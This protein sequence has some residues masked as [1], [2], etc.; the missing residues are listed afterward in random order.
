MEKFLD[1]D[2]LVA[3][4]Q[5]VCIWRIYKYQPHFNKMEIDFV[6]VFF[7]L[8]ITTI[9]RSPP[10]IFGGTSCLWATFS[11]IASFE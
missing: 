5:D 9:Q 1:N 8:G 11:F 7:F 10:P 3:L 2:G 4:F 6:L